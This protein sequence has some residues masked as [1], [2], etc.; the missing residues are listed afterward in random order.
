MDIHQI[1]AFQ[2][3]LEKIAGV[4]LNLVGYKSDPTLTE[5]K[6]QEMRDAVDAYDLKADSMAK[7]KRLYRSDFMKSP[8]LLGRLIGERPKFDQ[9]GYDTHETKR[10]AE[11]DKIYKTLGPSPMEPYD[12]ARSL[13]VGPKDTT[14][15]K[16][17]KYVLG[18]RF[19]DLKGLDNDEAYSDKE[20]SNYLD[21]KKLDKVVSLYKRNMSDYNRPGED[22][23]HQ[24]FLDRA[25]ALKKDPSVK[26]YRLEWG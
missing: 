8:G 10:R 15:G 5:K 19:S 14:S 13:E 20:Y 22:E 7:T 18:D 12:V 9:A 26:G 16:L 6:R 17:T 21:D 2:D 24:R 23:Y 11:M 4:E 3:E 1:R 25:A